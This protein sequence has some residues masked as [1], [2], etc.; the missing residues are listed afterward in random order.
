[1]NYNKKLTQKASSTEL[2]LS[3]NFLSN[4]QISEDSFVTIEIS[5]KEN[6]NE[7]LTN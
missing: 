4:S 7:G 1:M 5:K 2:L 6:S 3:V